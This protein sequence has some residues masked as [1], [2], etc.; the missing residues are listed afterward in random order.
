MV[1]THTVGR[2]VA[3]CA[4][5]LG[6]TALA[7]PALAQTGQ[8]RGKVVDA[9]NKP[10]EGAKV[11]IVLLDS[12]TKLEVKTKKN[13]EYL[14]IGLQPG[15]YKVTAE[16]DTLTQEFTVRVG[17]DMKELNFTLKPGGSGGEM[18]KE[19]A[20]KQAAKVAGLKAAFSEGAALTNAGKF[21]EAIAKFN[22]VL[23]AVPK[24][25]ECYVNIGAAYAQKK[26]Y[27]ESEAAFRKA[28]EV[29]PNSAEAYNGL[30]TIFNDQKKFTEAQAMSAEASKR[31]AAA[32]G[33]GASAD[34]LY[35]QG[36]I[37]WNAQEFTKAHEAFAAA[38]AANP[39]HAES[40]FMLGNALVKVG[41]TSGDM[42]KL[43]EAATEFET[44]LKLAP[45][46]PNAGKAKENFEQLKSFK[47]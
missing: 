26:Q 5:V 47:K 32:G 17:L 23:V 2:T 8:L 25:T 33:G 21:D 31:S 34:Q 20:A 22:E 27:A 40:H 41:A 42:A 6:L 7:V 24:C 14:Q 13:G 11:S 12:N 38:V 3:I 45:T 28:I 9:Q 4:V 43:G 39:N 19:E 10:V 35:N 36:V 18:T 15:N 1:G 16:K 46:G 30:A 44:Y 37:A 29:D